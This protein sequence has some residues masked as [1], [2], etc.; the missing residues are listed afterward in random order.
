MPLLNLVCSYLFIYDC[1]SVD[2]LN[3]FEEDGSCAISVI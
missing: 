3:A 2:G 1:G